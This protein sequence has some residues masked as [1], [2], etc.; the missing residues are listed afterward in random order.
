MKKLNVLESI[1]HDVS[2]L[3]LSGALGRSCRRET[4]AI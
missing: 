3:D 4:T 1:D 2:N